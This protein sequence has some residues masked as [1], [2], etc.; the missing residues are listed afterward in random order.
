M[1]ENVYMKY[2]KTAAMLPQ[3]RCDNHLNALEIDL[4]HKSHNAPVPYPAMHR[5]EQKCAHL[6]SE[7]CI[8]GYGRGALWDL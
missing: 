3:S 1:Q 2:M 5:S 8:V 4:I 7:C 6:C